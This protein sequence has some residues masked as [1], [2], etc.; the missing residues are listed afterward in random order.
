MP[1]QFLHGVE[2]V[3]I[4]SGPRPIRTVRSS[5]IEDIVNGCRQGTISSKGRRF[6]AFARYQYGSVVG[7]QVFVCIRCCA[8]KPNHR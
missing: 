7:E 8:N 6:A 5:V 1:E 3:E 4:D 2:V